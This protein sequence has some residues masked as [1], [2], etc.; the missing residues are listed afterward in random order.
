MSERNNSM[1]R[2]EVEEKF[3]WNLADIY[4][5]DE[6][7][8]KEYE[9]AKAFAEKNASFAGKLGSNAKTLLDFYKL[10]DEE[11]VVITKLYGYASQKSDEDTANPKYQGMKGKAIGLWVNTGSSMAFSTPEIMAIPN[12]TIEKF[13]AECDDL[14][15]Y[16]RPIDKIR[17][18]KE[19][20]LSPECE[21]LLASAGELATAPET[22]SSTFED[23]DLKFGDYTDK[24]G[25][26]TTITGANFVH[27]LENADVD[28]RR[29]VFNLYYKRFSEFKNTSAAIIN[30]QFK[31]LNF[32]AK[33]RKYN[34]TLEAALDN[35]EVPT[36]VYLNLID[37][38]HQNFDK[39][40]R[41]VALRKKL[42][43]VSELHMYDVYTPLVPAA[44]KEIPFSDAKQIVL[45]ALSV[46]GTDYTDLLKFAF[47]NRWIDIYPNEGKRGGAYS[48][49]NSY[50]HPFVL[51]NQMDN[52]DSCFTL[53][54]EMG[55][56]LHSYHSTKY[57]PI[58]QNE[59][60]IFVAEV[61]STVNEVLTM[62][63]LL[64]K[65]T[66]KDE[67]AYLINH[68]LDQFK[69]TVYRQT[70]FAEFELFMG[71]KVEAGETLTSEMLCEKYLELN[72]A[73]YGP[74]MVSDDLI[75]YEWQRIPHFYY[76]Y[77]V[78]QYA[79]GF[80]AA[81]A[82]ANKILTEGK[83]AVD[84]YKKFLSSGG[85]QDPISLLKIAGVDMSTPEPINE[86]LKLFDQLI[87]ELENI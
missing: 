17:H 21:Q 76:N 44:N 56:A 85:S 11:T 51:L 24:N 75:Q 61:A 25:K 20:I 79:T 22:I 43:G 55:H 64:G 57:Q 39:M 62:R 10:Q 9:N 41:Y 58:C 40:H 19:H 63:Y 87:S 68:F 26:T 54:H 82:I 71:Q 84:N 72:K 83:P 15:V 12:E 81:C 27:M 59:Y 78:F 16:K 77:Y 6:A 50:P 42:L 36:K 48:S 70:M 74:D 14:K 32:F 33:A 7:W 29:D 69:G 18:M 30:S 80:S 4:A 45:D 67:R 38:V 73:Y 35:T 52:L 65:T 53:A 49:G 8:E 2:S 46:L 86:G 1:K 13:Y 5:S 31:Q 34:S 23:A 66:D 3:T 37:A 47:D 28:I 60:V